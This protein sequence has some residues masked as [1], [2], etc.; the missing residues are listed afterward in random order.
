MNIRTNILELSFKLTER[1]NQSSTIIVSCLLLCAALIALSKLNNPDLFRTVTKSFFSLKLKESDFNDNSRLKLGTS[2]LLNFN[3]IITSTI[4][5]FLFCSYYFSDTNALF[6][7]L[8]FSSY[9]IIIQQLGFR[10][11]ALLTGEIQIKFY[12]G[13]ITKQIWHFSGFFLLIV[14]LVWSLNKST[15]SS[16]SVIYII[17]FIILNLIRFIKGVSV[18]F[19]IGIKWYYLILYICTL[20]ILPAL[21]FYH[22][23]INAYL[24]F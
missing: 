9:F 16:S 18:S 24:G 14:A 13:Y 5:L 21:L 8:I 20:E 6:Y 3:F 17:Y 23:I 19:K 22:F 4:C 11:A 10:L 2:L 7:S 15:G 12:V 1:M